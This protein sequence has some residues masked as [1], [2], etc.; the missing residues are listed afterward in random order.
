M[1]KYRVYI[2]AGIE[3]NDELEAENEEEAH[4]KA[5]ALIGHRDYECSIEVTEIEKKLK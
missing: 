4:E 2:N 1:K 3:I 5:Y